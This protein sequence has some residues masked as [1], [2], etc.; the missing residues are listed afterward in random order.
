[1]G[2]FKIRRRE[3][4]EPVATIVDDAYRLAF[5]QAPLGI[6]HVG[7]DGGLSAV[8]PALCAI[9]RR[10]PAELAATTFVRLTHPA[11]IESDIGQIGRLLRG[12]IPRY[13]ME[14]RYLLPDG[15]HIWARLHVSLRRDAAGNPLHF[16]SMVEEIPTPA[17][18]AA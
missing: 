14:K 13:T 7:M 4:N 11:D 3:A 5:D 18:P 15:S 10:T 1:M 8:N 16:I 9:L 17:D 2:F 6:A 12:D